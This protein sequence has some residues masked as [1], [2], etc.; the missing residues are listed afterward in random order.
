MPPKSRPLEPVWASGLLEELDA[1]WVAPVLAGTFTLLLLLA[2][3][4]GAVV[5]P[6]SSP[7]MPLPVSSASLKTP[8]STTMTPWPVPPSP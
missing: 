4:A 5:A 2:G 3:A 7:P 1:A 6:P 8:P